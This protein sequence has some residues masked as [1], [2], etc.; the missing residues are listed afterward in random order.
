MTFSK[1]ILLQLKSFYS[2]NSKNISTIL[3]LAYS[4]VFLCFTYTRCFDNF[5]WGDEGYSIKLSQMGGG[6]YA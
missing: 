4:L 6:I 2:A 3:I 5:F 1:L